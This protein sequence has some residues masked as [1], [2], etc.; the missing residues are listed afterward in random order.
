MKKKWVQIFIALGYSGFMIIYYYDDNT[1]DRKVMLMG[2]LFI[3]AYMLTLD[4]A[5]KEARNE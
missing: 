2:T 3:I 5:R 4:I 1:S